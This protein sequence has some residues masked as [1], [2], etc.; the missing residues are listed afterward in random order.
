MGGE[1]DLQT[2]SETFYFYCIYPRQ[3]Q[4]YNINMFKNRFC[5]KPED[6][7]IIS[8]KNLIMTPSFVLPIGSIYG[9]EELSSFNSNIELEFNPDRGPYHQEWY[10]EGEDQKNQN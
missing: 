1:K 5:I 3:S 2:L 9:M 7:T 10:G 4:F 8:V 6:N